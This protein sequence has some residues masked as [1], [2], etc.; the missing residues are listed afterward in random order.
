MS[1]QL[2]FGP[3]LEQWDL[4]IQAIGMTLYVSAV[5]MTLATVIGLVV[6]LARMS[7]IPLLASGAKIYVHLFRG[8]PLYVYIIW[9]YYGLALFLGI[10][11]SPLQAGIICLSTLYGAYLAE[12]DRGALQSIP[13]EQN[14]AA[15]A[16][17][18]T[19]AQT[20]R[21]IILPQALRT[22][23]PP[24]TNMFAVMIMDSSLL[25]VIGVTDLMRLVRTGASESFRSLEFYTV[26]AVVYV[27]LVLL[28]TRF[29]RFLE[30]KFS[31]S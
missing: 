11:L 7:G 28:F 16:L 26:G 18:L 22:I 19:P 2:N 20:F 8:V 4:F 10:K 30:G 12:I 14:E 23:I 21:E 15:L 24:T 29:S 3:V 1:Y 17:G 13:K 31:Y 6:A 27:F 5:S 25:S 9:L